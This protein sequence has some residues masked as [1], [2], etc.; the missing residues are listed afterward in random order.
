M[1]TTPTAEDMYKYV[2]LTIDRSRSD[3][4]LTEK[5]KKLGAVVK[6]ITTEPEGVLILDMPNQRAYQGSADD[7]ADATLR[8]TCDTANRF[9]QGDVNLLTAVNT[10]A[11]ILEGKMSVLAK[12]LPVAQEMFPTYIALLK[13]DGR[14]DLLV[15]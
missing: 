2:G 5:F 3:E 1:P 10:R 7:E 13:S 9:W 11:V 4:K 12:A 6:V 14:T 15:G 8:M